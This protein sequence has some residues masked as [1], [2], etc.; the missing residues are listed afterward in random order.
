MFEGRARPGR[1]EVDLAAAAVQARSAPAAIGSSDPAWGAAWADCAGWLEGKQERD[2][3]ALRL[4]ALRGSPVPAEPLGARLAA[5]ALALGD[6]VVEGDVSRAAQASARLVGLGSGLTPSGDDFL[7]GVMAALWCTGAEGTSRARFRDAWG[8]ALANVL[9]RTNEVSATLLECAIA[10]SFCGALRGLA[11]A[12]ARGGTGGR[13]Q[14]LHAAMGRLCAWGHSSGMDTATGFLF[15][16]SLRAGA[17]T[18]R[19]APPI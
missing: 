18:R 10:G 2:D 7:C 11:A 14:E 1:L 3:A 13:A 12:L 17:E 6:S 9:D 16:L 15:G 5:G 19:D 4:A 8:A